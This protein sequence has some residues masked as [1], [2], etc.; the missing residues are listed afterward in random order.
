MC[1]LS[2]VGT[3]GVHGCGL[4]ITLDTHTKCFC[5]VTSC[6]VDCGVLRVPYDIH[7]LY[8]LGEAVFKPDWW[9][10]DIPWENIACDNH[11][12]KDGETWASCLHRCINVCLLAHG[13]QGNVLTCM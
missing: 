7:L 2:I 13:Y 4:F 12:R 10:D 3:R 11:A 9:P 8:C 6:L 5:V 1:Q